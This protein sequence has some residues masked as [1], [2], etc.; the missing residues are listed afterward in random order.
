M[1][2]PRGKGGDYT[3]SVRMARTSG[4]I[5]L[6]KPSALGDICR[7]MPVLASLRGAFPESAIDWVVQEEFVDVVRGHPDVA[8]AVAFPRNRWRKWWN[9][10]VMQEA[11]GF[12]QKIRSNKYSLA[13]DLQG[14]FRSGWILHSTHAQR[15]VGWKAAPEFAWLGANERYRR[16]GGPDAT[17]IMLALL[18]D[19]GVPPIRD[20]KIEVPS[21]AVAAWHVRRNALPR[22]E[23]YAVLA[24]SSRW[25]SKRWPA[26]RW[27]VL[28]E[29]LMARG[30]QVVMVGAPGESEQ[31]R[32]AMPRDGAT[33]L[34]GVISVGQWLAAI[35]GA[36]IVVAN[37]SAAVH[38]AAGLGRA[39]VGIY[40]ATDPAAVGPYRRSESVVAP[41]GVAPS[42]PHAYRDDRLVQRM[43][44]VSVEAVER[45]VD[46][47]LERGHRW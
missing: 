16:R 1:E 15:R 5:L 32:N 46:Q 23:P 17:E 7:S 2:N 36:S 9:F 26:E 11:L 41:P 40:G 10:R 24:P 20:A 44:L 22:Q 37:D 39:L 34:C 21:D 35:Q 29:R 31:I 38:A 6:I 8:Q 18:E 25:K 43:E 19:A 12:G 42:D 33:D 3:L 14:L 28:A 45:K 27:K 47:E 13:V 4:R 30:M